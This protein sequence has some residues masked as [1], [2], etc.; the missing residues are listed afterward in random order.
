MLPLKPNNYLQLATKKMF[1][2]KYYQSNNGCLNFCRFTVLLIVVTSFISGCQSPPEPETVIVYPPHLRLASAKEALAYNIRLQ[3]LVDT[4]QGVSRQ[5][6]EEAFNVQR[7]WWDR[8]WPLVAVA[9]TELTVQTQKKRNAMGEVTGQLDALKFELDAKTDSGTT[10]ESYI[11]TSTQ[12]EILCR[13]FLK[14]YQAGDY[15]LIKK[16]SHYPILKSMLKDYPDQANSTPQRVPKLNHGFLPQRQYGRSILLAFRLAQKVHCQ[17]ADLINM[18]NNWPRELYGSYCPGR[19]PIAIECHWG[20][21]NQLL[22]SLEN[23]K[24]ENANKE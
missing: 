19:D 22:E 13:F 14:Q 10:V 24:L 1:K 23:N 3:A 7:Q 4:C 21:C 9:D 11:K 6:S 12:P 16:P 15:D 8:N 17:G 2:P 18:L 5:S 20:E